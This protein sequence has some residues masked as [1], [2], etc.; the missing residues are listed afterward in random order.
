MKK[1]IQ[2]VI[3]AFFLNFSLVYISTGQELIPML[4]DPQVKE[5]VVM[6]TY[7]YEHIPDFTYEEV[8]KR[9]EAMPVEMRFNL[10]ETIY[11]FID[12]FTVRNREYTRMVLSR[13]DI[14]FPMFEEALAKHQMPDDIKYLAIVESGLNPRAKSPV[15]A[16]GLWQFM[17]ATGG[18]Y[19]LYVNKHIDDRMDP[20]KATEAAVKYLKALHRMFGDWE[21]AL[22]AYNCGPGNVRKAIRRSGGKRSFW[23]IYNYL[24]RETRSYIPQFQAIMYVFHYA[25]KHNL[26]L[27]E[28]VFPMAHEKVRFDTEINLDH[29]AQIAGICIEDIEEL[30]P[31]ILNRQIPLSNKN[32]ALKIPKAKAT[33]LAENKDWIADSLSLQAERLIALEPELEKEA[34]TQLTGKITYRI[35]PGDALGRIA[36]KHNTTVAN[37]KKWNG[38]TSNIIKPGQQLTIYSSNSSFETSLVSAS[39]ESSDQ[40]PQSSKVYTVQPGDSLWLISRKI[41][42]VTIEQIKKLNN[43]NNNEIKPGQKL[44]IG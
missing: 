8:Q 15:G 38:L 9:I 10:N 35:K 30:N 44:I 19:K 7:N 14:F 32:F 1:I 18:E 3:I 25:E 37:L 4:N 13:K 33:F 29:F 11:G 20:E 42:G 34:V 5:E 39:T 36:I 6:P 16:M 31:S 43:L 27:E 28:P 21:M 41:E 23:G 24:P 2:A 12:Y 26:I 17:P 22:A 40:N